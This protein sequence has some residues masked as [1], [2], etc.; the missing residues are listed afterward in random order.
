MDDRLRKTED[1]M[2]E[3]GKILAVTVDQTKNNSD[4]VKDLISTLGKDRDILTSTISELQT[5]RALCAKMMEVVEARVEAIEDS[6]KWLI[7]GVLGSLGTILVSV[8]VIL[9][10]TKLI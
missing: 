4:A 10:R 1:T 6:Q 9:V 3:M 5:K 7:R 2:I 8:I